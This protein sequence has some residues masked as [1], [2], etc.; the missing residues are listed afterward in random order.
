MD[1]NTSKPLSTST[2]SARTYIL[3][4]LGLVIVTAVELF[5][6]SSMSPFG[7]GTVVPI[8]LLLML[9]KAALVAAFY[10]HL[11]YDTRLYTFIF[12]VPVILLSVFAFLAVIS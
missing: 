4:F 5:L 3:V 12:V 7:R 9:V 6:L 1:S 2:S 11:R 10:M 8:F